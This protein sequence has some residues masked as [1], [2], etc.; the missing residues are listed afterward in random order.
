M[1]LFC[2][3]VWKQVLKLRMNRA[4]EKLGREWM[5]PGVWNDVGSSGPRDSRSG[6]LIAM[7][8][9]QTLQPTV[10][11]HAEVPWNSVSKAEV[12]EV[13][14]RS[15]TAAHILNSS[16]FLFDIF[17]STSTKAPES[18]RNA[19][20]FLLNAWSMWLVY[21]VSLGLRDQGKRLTTPSLHQEFIKRIYM[22]NT[23]WTAAR[24]QRYP[25]N[26]MAGA[27]WLYGTGQD[28]QG[29]GGITRP[30]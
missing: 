22:W 14:L 13:F 17:L 19:W 6:G 2:S 12:R 11:A 27:K 29:G 24:L 4:S 26:H 15:R 9:L 25:P 21:K 7:T 1:L 3:Q 18:R 8:C 16:W 23:S 30:R 10:N 28:G 5:R 20:V